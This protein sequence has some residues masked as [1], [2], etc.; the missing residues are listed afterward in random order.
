MRRGGCGGAM[1]TVNLLDFASLFLFVA[2]PE[3]IEHERERLEAKHGLLLVVW[4][5]EYPTLSGCRCTRITWMEDDMAK[6]PIGPREARLRE[7]R[8]ARVAA[9]KKLIDKKSK[10]AGKSKAKKRG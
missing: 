2:S 3:Q 10:R 9:N 5:I 6:Q 8:E 7:M 4:Q 1:K